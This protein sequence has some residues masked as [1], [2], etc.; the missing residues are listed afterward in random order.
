MPLTI[1]SFHQVGDVLGGGP[2]R[3]RLDVGVVGGHGRVGMPERP[4]A[5]L[6]VDLY[7]TGQAGSAVPSARMR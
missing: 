6:R 2:E 3:L 4:A 7:I 5:A 1:R